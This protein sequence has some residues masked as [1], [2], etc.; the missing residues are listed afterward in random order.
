MENIVQKILRNETL[1][2][3]KRNG[4]LIE[5]RIKRI[6]QSREMYTDMDLLKALAQNISL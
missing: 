4:C 6:L 3:K 1:R 2:K 5:E